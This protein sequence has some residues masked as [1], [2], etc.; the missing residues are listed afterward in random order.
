MSDKLL[1]TV[2]EAA[3]LCGFSKSFLYQ[4]MGRGEI[5]CI[6][7]GRTARIPRAW[8]EKWVNEQV[9]KWEDARHNA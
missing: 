6:R 3:A 9:A 5:P 4:A 7:L 1:L 2:R 8:L